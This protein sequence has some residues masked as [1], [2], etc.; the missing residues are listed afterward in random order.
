MKFSEGQLVNLRHYDGMWRVIRVVP[1]KHYILEPVSPLS[2]V[3]EVEENISSVEHPFTSIPPPP[4]ISENPP[5]T[6]PTPYIPTVTKEYLFIGGRYDGCKLEVTHKENELPP[7]TVTTMK[8]E[9]SVQQVEYVRWEFIKD[10]VYVLPPFKK[11][12]VRMLCDNYAQ[13]HQSK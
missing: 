4:T 7:R 8:D 5:H 9:Y 2:V 10:I 6:A 13:K 12:V 1:N 3:Q 11:Y